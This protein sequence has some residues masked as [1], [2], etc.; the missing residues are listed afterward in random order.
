MKFCYSVL[1]FCYIPTKILSFTPNFEFSVKISEVSNTSVI[2][3]FGA[4]ALTNNIFPFPFDL[5]ITMFIQE[6]TKWSLTKHS[7]RVFQKFVMNDSLKTYNAAIQTY[8]KT[9]GKD[10]LICDEYSYQIIKMDEMLN[11]LFKCR[12]RVTGYVGWL[13]TSSYLYGDLIVNRSEMTRKA[14]ISFKALFIIGPQ[15]TLTFDN[16]FNYQLFE[17]ECFADRKTFYAYLLFGILCVIFLVLK[18]FVFFLNVSKRNDINQSSAVDVRSDNW[19]YDW[20]KIK[21]DFLVSQSSFSSN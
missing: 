5:S 8:Y 15:K 11:Q 9:R 13:T 17:R 2:E 7:P 20:L 1:I 6:V 4:K 10:L 14:T 16:F 18:I 12:S 19:N 21:F 3:T